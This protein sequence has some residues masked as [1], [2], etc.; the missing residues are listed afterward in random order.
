MTGIIIFFPRGSLQQLVI[1]LTLCVFLSWIHHNL[2]PYR[3]DYDDCLAQ[4]AQSVIFL[5]ICSKIIR[6]EA[7]LVQPP[8]WWIE[9]TDII[10][11][12][13]LATASLLAGMCLV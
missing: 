12:A 2:K 9:M 13:L 7:G 4:F 10:M 3:S 6:Q 1:G 11:A 5:N 8:P